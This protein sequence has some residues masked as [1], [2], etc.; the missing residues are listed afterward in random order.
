M[1]Y[2]LISIQAVSY[3]FGA[4]TPV[5]CM[6]LSE[7]DYNHLRILKIHFIHH[8]MSRGIQEFV[9][10]RHRTLITG[11]NGAGKAALMNVLASIASDVEIR[12]DRE[13]MQRYREVIII[14]G[15]NSTIDNKAL[16]AYALDTL[17][18]A[19]I[20]NEARINFKLILEKKA[21]KVDI[22]KDLNP[23]MMALGEKMC[24]KY[25][26]L[27]AIRQ[28][29][30]LYLPVIIDSPYGLLDN[31]LR[32]GFRDFLDKQACQQILLGTAA[33]FHGDKA[34]YNLNMK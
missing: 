34:H 12:G 17:D 5:V 9:F 8:K 25:A 22:Y 33:E 1:T 6:K 13:L 15:V 10:D 27:F 19:E 26:Y 14:N 23:D 32:K 21:W 30:N 11:N 7:A 29:L 28:A 2:E 24:F 18:Q 3:K 20:K 31:E 4:N 16:H